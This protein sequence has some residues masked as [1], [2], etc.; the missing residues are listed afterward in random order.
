MLRDKLKDIE[1][2]SYNSSIAVVTSVSSNYQMVIARKEK[3]I[4]DLKE[5]LVSANEKLK[6][7][8]TGVTQ[9]AT[10]AEARKKRDMMEMLDFEIYNAENADRSYDYNVV[11][12]LLRTIK[13]AG[14]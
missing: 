1:R 11:A 3:E 6:G 4:A 13:E 5:Q 8:R 14:K 2:I 9:V 12:D 10:N 7:W